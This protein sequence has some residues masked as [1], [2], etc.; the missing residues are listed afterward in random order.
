LEV[1]DHIFV[2]KFAYGVGIPFTNTKILQLARPK[3]GD[4]IVFKYPLDQ[5]TD[6]IKRVVGLPGETVE[7]RRNEVFI[8]GKSMARELV[9]PTRYSDG[10]RY[11]GVALE[12]ECELW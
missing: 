6:Y 4:V 2:S 11:E 5:N 3:R 8:N 7:V 9:G 10:P 1:G 12:R